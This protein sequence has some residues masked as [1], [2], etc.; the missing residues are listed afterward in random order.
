MRLI[1]RGT[2]DRGEILIVTGPAASGK[3]SVALRLAET[4]E[5]RSVHL[6]TDDFFHA[7]KVGRLRGW[8]DGAEPQH[9]VAFEAVAS[10]ASAYASG[11]YFVVL[12]SFI[13][14]DYL[15][16]VKDVI[17]VNEIALHYVA[18]R[19]SLS[20]T[21]LRSSKREE[22]KRHRDE[23]LDE[24]HGAFNDLGVLESHVVDNTKLSVSQTAETIRVRMDRRELR[25]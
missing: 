11:G 16:V 25:I 5:E 20:E 4:S 6:H 12:D 10:A 17:N 24:L 19:P 13:R 8:E 1:G 22:N 3:T 15:E 7:L 2:P 23:V 9:Q 18:L 21:R 14:L